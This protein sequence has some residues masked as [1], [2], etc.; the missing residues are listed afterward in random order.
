MMIHSTYLLVKKFDA[1]Q[2][3]IAHD[4]GSS[5]RKKIYPEYKAPRAKGREESP[6]DFKIFFK[7]MDEFIADFKKAIPN[8][9]FY[10]MIH[11]KLTI[12]LVYY[13]KN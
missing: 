3:I 7:V 13:L 8:V 6:I 5:W 11:M 1:D 10:I 12:S 9:Y 4:Q 2:L